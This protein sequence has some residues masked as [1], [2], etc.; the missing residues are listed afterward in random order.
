MLSK[1][2]LT[3]GYQQIYGENAAEEVE[4]LFYKVDMDGSGYID[5]SEWVVATID[6]QKLLTKEKLQ[7]AF[8]LFDKNGGGT[9]NANE[10]KEVLCSG[11]D[12]EENMWEKIQQEIKYVDEDGSGELEFDEFCLMMQK[13]ILDEE[14]NE[15]DF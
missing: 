12:Y 5:Y 11:Q 2:E 13:M 8:N 15:D 9:I 1:E 7:S 14:D 4:K 10:V 6:K 3:V